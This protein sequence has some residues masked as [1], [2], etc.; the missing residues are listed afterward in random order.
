MPHVERHSSWSSSLRTLAGPTSYA[1][2]ITTIVALLGWVG[3]C[4]RRQPALRR[5]DHLACHLLEASEVD[6]ARHRIRQ[7]GLEH[8]I[9]LAGERRLDDQLLRARDAAQVLAEDRRRARDVAAAD[10]VAVGR[11]HAL[12]DD[13]VGEV[14]R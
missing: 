10:A 9:A 6:P 12:D 3:S 4:E 2:L 11:A 7:H 1:F 14:G 5:V 13:A 8:E